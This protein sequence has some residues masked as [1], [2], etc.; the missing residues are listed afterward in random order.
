MQAARGLGGVEQ[1]HDGDTAHSPHVSVDG[2]ATPGTGGFDPAR[3][4]AVV[5]DWDTAP[6]DVDGL[7]ARLRQLSTLGVHAV[8]TG[9]GGEGVAAQLLGLRTHGPGRL[10]FLSGDPSQLVELGPDGSRAGRRTRQPATDVPDEL[11]AWAREWLLDPDDPSV[12][13]LVSAAGGSV[14]STLAFL[15]EV[16]TA[17]H[18]FPVE[19]EDPAWRLEVEGFDRLRE[20]EVESWLSV[21]N[22]RTGTRG[23]LEEGSP[24]SSPATYAAG[25]FGHV[26]GELPGP[27]L[28]P[29]P[30]WTHLRPR[31]AGQPV[32]LADGETIEHR[33]TLDLRQ[34]ILFRRWRQ[35][36]P[37][38]EEWSFRS[39]RF[40]SLAERDILALEAEAT[41]D[42]LAVSLGDGLPAARPDA[43]VA[44]V[45]RRGGDG[46]EVVTVSGKDGQSASYAV[47][48]HEARGRLERLVA[49]HR[50]WGDDPAVDASHRLARA[51]VAGLPAL[52]ARHRLEWRRRW[53]DADVT[54]PGDVAL[55][56]AVR[57]AL[58]HLIS[59][60]DPEADV[61]SIGARGLTGPGYKGHVFWD[62]EVF[63]LPF[64]IWTHPP[65]ARALLSYRHRTLPAARAK[66]ADLGYSGALYAWESADTGAEVAP[67]F[68]RAFDGTRVEILTGLREHHISAD[69]AWGT[70]QY[71][72]VTHDEA[73]LVEKGAE[74]ILETARFWASRAQRGDDGRFHIDRVIGPDEYHE[75]ADDSAFTNVL[76]R[77]NL[78]TAARVC[79]LVPR[80]DRS[81]WQRLQA[82]L[83]LRTPELRWWAEVGEGLVDGFDRESL[84]YEQF[85]GFFALE[86]VR[87]VDVAP[88]P[89]TADT[90]LGA[91]RVQGAQVVKQADVLMLAHMLPELVPA[92]VL[93]ANYR[94][95][96]PRTSHGSSLS[97]PVHAAVAARVGALADADHYFRMAAAIDL[98]DR[99][100][101]SA[102]GVHLATMG[103]LWQAAA[104]GFGGVRADGD[105]L[106]IDPRIP[107]SWEGLGFSV[108]WR[109]T[110]VGVQVGPT[111]LRVD[112]DGPLILGVGS[113]AARPVEAGGFLARRQG[114]GWSPLERVEGGR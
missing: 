47:S 26:A 112:V 57:F 97:P 44:S 10:F 79:D 93:E 100:G 86:D 87:A 105:A 21:A 43:A 102:L 4:G 82:R 88:R 59:S 38:G 52:R 65:T 28:I 68:A 22:G 75:D 84:L 50:G 114:S 69:V 61:A 74:M 39:A 66:A 12:A 42:A 60:G 14:A 46:R 109:G 77:W 48:T 15:D 27:E 106:R 30:E 41:T 36:L 54:L 55:Q 72:Q 24:G 13:V 58:A 3:T 80:L 78:A 8:L 6:L 98:D 31:V 37:S 29:G 16:V 71:W 111:S 89:F 56:R 34:G 92:E 107:P 96:E 7:G 110:R 25:V 62:T 19:V 104:L 83:H 95:Y 85:A 73:F 64:F 20:R 1:A 5:I 103:G 40:A 23:S 76:A 35:R 11:V 32:D 108:R 53:S 33:R 70:W 45:V 91:H 18:G 113:E 99:M 51:E 63:V 17:H 94:Y 2:A 67:L 90:I 101:N 81:G 9:P 49:V